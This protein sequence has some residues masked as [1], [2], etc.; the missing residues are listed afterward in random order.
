MISSLDSD[1][2]HPS[3]ASGKIAYLDGWRGLAIIL[4]LA[5]HFFGAPFNYV[6]A[7]GVFLFFALSGLFMSQMLFIRKMDLATFL[8]RRISRVVPTFWLFTACMIIYG[9]TLQSTRYD[10]PPAEILSTLLFLR[11]YLPTDIGIWAGKLP[12]G[13]FWSLN[14]EEHSYAF[15]ALGAVLFNKSARRNMPLMFLIVSTIIV[16]AINLVYLIS[17]PES[18]SPWFVRTEAAS[19]GLLVSAT[20]TLFRHR[21]RFSVLN[22]MLSWIP[23]FAFLMAAML[24][25]SGKMPL[26][27]ISMF[28][29]AFAVNHLDTA[30]EFCRRMLSTKIMRWFGKCSFSIYLWQQPFFMLADRYPEYRFQLLLS[31]LMTACIS[32]YCFENPIR[33]AINRTWDKHRQT[34]SQGPQSFSNN[35]SVI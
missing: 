25:M 31:A 24:F 27:L 8:V 19:M 6:G 29:L 26:V 30:P 22:S 33:E 17:P 10:M 16:L 13:H 32:F 18:A 21:N 14:V 23:L 9:A 4:V 3:V 12:I 7:F 1:S 11:T 20:Y 35:S 28:L 34:S 2:S 15:L 5:F